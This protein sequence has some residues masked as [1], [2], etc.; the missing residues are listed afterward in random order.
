M[1]V[2]VRRNQLQPAQTRY[3]RRRFPERHR[4]AIHSIRPVCEVYSPQRQ[5]KYK[6]KQKERRDT[7]KDELQNY[8]T[9]LSVYNKH[10]YDWSLSS[11]SYWDA[12]L[13]SVFCPSVRP[14]VTLWHY[15]WTNAL[16]IRICW[17]VVWDVILRG[18]NCTACSGTATICPRP[19]QVVTWTAINSFKFGVSDLE[20]IIR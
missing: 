7:I 1:Y 13:I 14:S 16:R 11:A 4:N 20:V 17:H 19:L 8:T 10:I 15:V 6:Q 3:G 2:S 9:K 12:I 5:T 18:T